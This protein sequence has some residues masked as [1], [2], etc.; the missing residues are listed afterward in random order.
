MTV[1]SFGPLKKLRKISAAVI[2]AAL[3]VSMAACSDTSTASL[4]STGASSGAEDTITFAIPS[5]PSSLNP[6]N[7]GDRYGITTTN[8]LYEPLARQE[9]DGTIVNEL[10]DKIEPAADDKSVTVT[11]KDGL[12][13]SDGEAITADDV[14][15]TYNAQADK[16]SGNADPLWI[17]GSPVKVEAVD[18][19]TVKFTLPTASAAAIA[20]VPTVSWII[21]KHVYGKVTDF[22]V[23][24]LDPIAV[25]SGPYKL[26]EYKKGEYLT[27]VRNDNYYGDKA[28]VGKIVF[29]IISNSATIKTALQTGEI[30]AAN[31]SPGDVDGLKNAPVNTYTYS[32]G[33]VGYIGFNTQKNLK[34][35]R[36]RQAFAYAID[37]T[38]IANAAYLSPDYYKLAYTILP[39]SNPFATTDVNKYERNVEKAK[40][41]LKEAGVSN[42][43]VNFAYTG[44]SAEQTAEA[45]VIQQ[46]AKE[47][48]FN[49][50]LQAGDSSTIQAEL[51]KGGDSKYDAFIG[52][53]IMSLDPDSYKQL[54][55]STASANFF[56]YKSDKVDQLF[57]QG[58]AETDEAKRKDIYNELQRQIAEDVP[59]YPVV[60][61]LKV[62]AVNKRITG[63]EDAKLVTITALENYGKLAVS[64]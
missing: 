17:G 21:P 2:G 15:F 22:S 61:N 28:K 3:A 27:F 38:A 11:L 30:D 39:P 19:K 46:Q 49:V 31:V 23:N 12:K 57:D 58:I 10:A 36:V 47:A 52:G 33:R 20:S 16:N 29:R 41:L 54:Y 53:Y 7:T 44:S 24:Q 35:V 43:T 48:G 50:N 34:D 6:I 5:D 9:A 25:G 40:E 55:E 37:R 51:D 1:G 14:V 56:G 45:T 60:D 18:Q 8:M 26:E 63:V 42:P 62:L 32:E 59:V 13:W 64:K 4:S